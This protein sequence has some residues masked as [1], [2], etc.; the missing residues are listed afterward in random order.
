MII[1]TVRELWEE[2]QRREGRRITLLEMSKETGINRNT[3]AKLLDP[4]QEPYTTTTDVIDKLCKYFGCQ[5][6]DIMKFRY[7]EEERNQEKVGEQEGEELLKLSAKGKVVEPLSESEFML[8]SEKKKLGEQKKK[9]T[10][11]EVV[12]LLKK[13]MEALVAAMEYLKKD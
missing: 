4:R 6:G 7:D 8:L 13:N 1:F 10:R 12:E 2:K 9:V 5:P 3:L 11:E